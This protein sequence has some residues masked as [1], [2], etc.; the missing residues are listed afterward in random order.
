[1]PWKDEWRKDLPNHAEMES[2]SEPMTSWITYEYIGIT[3][4][5]RDTIE[6]LESGI[7]QYHPC[8]V[9]NNG[10][11]FDYLTLKVNAFVGDEAVVKEKTK[12]AFIAEFKPAG[13]WGPE[14]LDKPRIVFK[15]DHVAGKHLFYYHY[16]LVISD[17]LH[18]ELDQSNLLTGT[19][20][21]YCEEE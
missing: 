12:I 4:K 13:W 18:R 20:L 7:H 8:C 3:S 1:M 6:K 15:R 11:R 17:L 14:L 5:V 9:E 2:T 16:Q 21:A 10:R 19:D